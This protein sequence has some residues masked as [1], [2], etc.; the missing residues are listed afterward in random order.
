MLLWIFYGPDG[1]APASAW[2]DTELKGL[3]ARGGGG[4]ELIDVVLRQVQDGAVR[5]PC[6]PADSAGA[7]PPSGGRRS[8]VI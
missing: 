2:L 3:R 7:R 5:T 1:E 6:R 4:W 8:R